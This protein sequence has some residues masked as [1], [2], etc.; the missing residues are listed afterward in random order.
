PDSHRVETEV[1][2]NRQGHPADALRWE[3]DRQGDAWQLPARRARA[4]RAH[5]AKPRLVRGH[6]PHLRLAVGPRGQLDREAVRNPGALLGGHDR[7]LRAPAAGAVHSGRRRAA[8]TAERDLAP[9]WPRGSFP[10]S[11]ASSRP[12]S[13]F[14]PRPKPIVG[15]PRAEVERAPRAGCYTGSTWRQYL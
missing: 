2:G 6:P 10:D 15:V 5:P 4:A 7:A 14:E 12:G 13:P 3:E 8:V 1:R 11:R 9:K